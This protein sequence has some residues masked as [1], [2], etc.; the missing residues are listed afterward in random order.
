MIKFVNFGKFKSEESLI[1]YNEY[2]KRISR[3]TNVEEVNFKI[4][5]D[6]PAYF[7]K[8][9]DKIIDA[10]KVGFNIVFSEY[11]EIIDSIKFSEYINKNIY[12]CNIIVGTSWGVPAFI[13]EHANL[14]IAVGRLTM[15][16]E[17]VKIISAEQV[18]RSL[19]IINGEKYNK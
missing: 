16:H 3:Y 13:Y 7:E 2:L 15:P 10:I 9:K 12:K 6:E 18:Y 19:T 8:I 1:L 17:L 5:K 4:L 11:G 14:K